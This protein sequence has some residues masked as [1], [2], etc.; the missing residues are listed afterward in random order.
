MHMIYK[1]EE[2]L[3]EDVKMPN[4]SRTA[5]QIVGMDKYDEKCDKMMKSVTSV[6]CLTMN[7]Y[8]YHL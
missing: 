4:I 6:T 7:Q 2:I 8:G 5:A 1:H 3:E